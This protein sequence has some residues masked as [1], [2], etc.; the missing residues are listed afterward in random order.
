[1][2]I[3]ADI[4]NN[5]NAVTIKYYGLLPVEKVNIQWG[6]PFVYGTCVFLQQ[7]I[8]NTLPGDG[9]V[10]KA[11]GGA[12]ILVNDVI[13]TSVFPGAYLEITTPVFGVVYSF[14][15]Q[16]V[17]SCG[18]SNIGTYSVQFFENDG[19]G[20]TQFTLPNMAK[21]QIVPDITF[22]NPTIAGICD[23]V[24]YQLE[25]IPPATSAVFKKNGTVMTTA[26]T[27]TNADT[28]SLEIAVNAPLGSHDLRYR[29]NGVCGRS[30]NA[31]YTFFIADAP[32]YPSMITQTPLYIGETISG[33]IG[34]DGDLLV[35]R[36]GLQVQA[37]AYSAGPWSFVPTVSG[38]YW[39][40]L[41]NQ[42]GT[43]GQSLTTVVIDPSAVIPPAPAVNTI[44]PTSVNVPIIIN[45]KSSGTLRIFKDSVE[46]GT[47]NVVF[48]NNTYV[49]TAAG[50]YQF[51]IQ[52]S[53]GLSPISST[54]VVN[55]SALSQTPTF[56]PIDS[57]LQ[58]PSAYVNFTAPEDGHLEFYNSDNTL[59][60]SVSRTAGQTWSHT[61]TV[62]SLIYAVMNATGKNKSAKTALVE[63]KGAVL[64]APTVTSP[65][66]I[67]I[68]AA[69]VL[70][71]AVDGTL[72]PFRN[73]NA[74]ASV[75]VTAGTYN[76]TPAL[77][78]AYNFKLQNGSGISDYTTTTNVVLAGTGGPGSVSV[79]FVGAFS[80]C[81]DIL[82]FGY[83]PSSDDPADVSLWGLS[84]VINVPSEGSYY[85]FARSTTDN[86][87]YWVSFVNTAGLG[88]GTGGGNGGSENPGEMKTFNNVYS[89]VEGVPKQ[90]NF[91]SGSEISFYTIEMRDTEGNLVL[92]PIP[93]ATRLSTSFLVAPD[94][95][96][97]D[98]TVRVVGI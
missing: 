44:S 9:A 91:E 6:T 13:D 69:I 60:V 39:F 76:Y 56:N 94:I 7:A 5:G 30:Y 80:A 81:G 12:N 1:M 18:E 17:G 87:K 83:H 15:Y 98:V 89:F 31:Q 42:F 24:S 79:V 68:G 34:A 49:A 57:D 52:N 41:R 10:L 59:L 28:I 73:G 78:G 82:E 66:Q 35:F 29:A 85:F 71:I 70:T 54:I 95:S 19:I 74:L 77:A 93:P 25:S 51:K 11:L 8:I 38:E 67:V 88:M 36:N 84:N 20:V 32:G 46:I 65:A 33:T 64:A 75:L 3:S 27:F 53:T 16:Y 55:S 40:K 4:V 45:V 23:F 21:G 63:V 96:V 48:G 37:S 61:V 72:I 26:T 62:P 43:S 86:L 97:N 92:M 47:K 90:I 2:A 22:P 14:T 50:N 58:L